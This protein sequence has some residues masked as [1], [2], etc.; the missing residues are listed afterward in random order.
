MLSTSTRYSPGTLQIEGQVGSIDF[1]E[2]AVVK[3]TNSQDERALRQSKLRGAVIEIEN[4][5]LVSGASR[6]AVEPTWNSARASWS[7]QR[8]SPVVSGRLGTAVTQSP[9]PP[10]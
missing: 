1:D 3:M 8:L 10:G 9:S 4:G 5:Q 7:V 6:I 2:I